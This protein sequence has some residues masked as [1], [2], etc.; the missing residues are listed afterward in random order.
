MRQQLLANARLAGQLLQTATVGRQ[1]EIG[2][3]F[4][5]LA[6]ML[7]EQNDQCLFLRQDV[8]EQWHVAAMQ[9]EGFGLQ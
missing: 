3:D 9:C 7:F 5:A 8:L 2:K 6:A 4:T 1:V